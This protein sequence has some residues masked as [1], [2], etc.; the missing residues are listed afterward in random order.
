MVNWIAG[1][2]NR[3]KALVSHAGPFNLENMATATEELW[4]P[5]WEYGGPFWDP[6]AMASQ[7]RV[8]SPHLFVK[9]FKT[10]TLVTGGELD[11]RVPYTEDLSMFTALQRMNVPS[12]LVIFPDEGH[13]IGKP[14]NQKLWWGEVQGWLEQVHRSAESV[15]PRKREAGSQI[16][17][18][19]RVSPGLSF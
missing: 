12:R 7:Y 18:R 14:Q 8:Y 4:F 10:P 17:K 6:K 9:N 19:A 16:T 13:W 15:G 5:D 1:H 2:T 11:Y 3:F